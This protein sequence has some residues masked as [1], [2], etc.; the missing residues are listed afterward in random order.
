MVGDNREMKIFLLT[1]LC[2]HPIFADTLPEY[3]SSDN[4]GISKGERIDMV[5]SYI[6][7]LGKM[8]NEISSKKLHDLEQELKTLKSEIGQNKNKKFEELIN[9][10]I[11]QAQEGLSLQIQNEV[12]KLED[13]LRTD[14]VK[15]YE[16]NKKLLE[17]LLERLAILEKTINDV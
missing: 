14:M 6:S 15:D 7:A 1:L 12:K 11:S 13:R 17:K 16:D 3:K 8:M 9:L 4:A 5:E 10:K 2:S